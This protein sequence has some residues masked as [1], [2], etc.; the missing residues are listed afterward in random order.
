VC[1]GFGDQYAA[2][3]A[4][5]RDDPGRAP[6]LEFGS[7]ADPLSRWEHENFGSGAGI[8]DH[9]GRASAPGR[10]LIRSVVSSNALFTENSRF[11]ALF[12]IRIDG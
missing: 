1:G 8:C 10:G 6:V 5:A 2:V 12:L 11:Q 9:D 7:F 4:A 3:A